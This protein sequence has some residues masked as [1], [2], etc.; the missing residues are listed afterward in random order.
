MPIS[1]ATSKNDMLMVKRLSIWR[2]LVEIALVFLVFFLHGAWP[3]PDVN[4]TGYVIKAVHFWNH[5]AFA[6]DFFC[7]TGDA[8]LVYYWA[9]GWLSK[10]GLSLDAMAWI[11]RIVTWLLLA[12][13]WHGLSFSVVSRPWIAVLSAEVFALLTEQ[14]HM[15]GEWIIGGVE[16]KGF[17]WALVLWSLQALVSGRW[18]VAWLLLGIA[19]SFHVVV[20]GWAAICLGIVWIASPRCRPPLTTML[21]AIGGFALLAAP[22]LFFAWRMNANVDWTTVVTADKIQVFERLPHHM[23]ST[24]FATGYVPRQLLLWALFILLCV[25][26]SASVGDRRLR[27]FIAAAMGISAVGFL[28]GWLA[29]LAPDCAASALRLYWFRLSDILVPCGVAIVGMQFLLNLF[30]LRRILARWL[31]AALLVLSA[32]DL[33]NQ[34]RHQPWLPEAWGRVNS[35][36][37]KFVVPDDW[38]DVCRWAAQNTPPGTVFITPRNSATFKWYAGRDEVATWKDMPQDAASV[39]EWCARMREIFGADQPTVAKPWRLS[40]AEAGASR[41]QEL[42]GKYGAQYAI[43]ELLPDMPRLSLQPVFKNGSYAIYR[44]GSPAGGPTA[45]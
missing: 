44:L 11:G 1:D 13:A 32:Y 41:L 39:V 31:L 34:V 25:Q 29:A 38:R 14:T 7:N 30:A 21:P 19:T 3:T 35:R 37:D 12:I 22:G 17:A 42:A 2:T 28:L 20:G 15:A 24:A 4:E 45:P 40:L 16:A 36:S 18:N 33:W 27:R 43:I 6:H 10:L 9:F 8:H 5:D 26:T 23:L